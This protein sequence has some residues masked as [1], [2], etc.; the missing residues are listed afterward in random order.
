MR[1]WFFRAEKLRKALKKSLGGQSETESEHSRGD[2]DS[3]EVKVPQTLPLSQPPE[4]GILKKKYPHSLEDL[5]ESS[6]SERQPLHKSKESLHRSKENLHKS[7]EKKKRLTSS[8]GQLRSPLQLTHDTSWL[9]PLQEAN[10]L[11][12]PAY[13]EFRSM[14]P[15]PPS[16][17]VGTQGDMDEEEGIYEELCGSSCSSLDKKEYSDEDNEATGEQ[18]DSAKAFSE[19]SYEMPRDSSN[20]SLEGA[21]NRII[22]LKNINELLKQIDEQFNSVLQQT[23]QGDYSPTGSEELRGS[24]TEADRHYNRD[25][26]YKQSDIEEGYSPPHRSPLLSPNPMGSDKRSSMVSTSDKRNSQLTSCSSP[27]PLP[28][29]TGILSPIR[30]RSPPR[31]MSPI[32]E[33]MRL[34]S[35]SSPLS[36]P[37]QQSV[38]SQAQRRA[39]I[40]GSPKR[41]S[42]ARRSSP[43]R[44][45]VRRGVSPSREGRGSR[46]GSTSP[47]ECGG[48]VC[49]PAG[50]RTRHTSGSPGRHM[51]PTSSH[52]SLMEPPVTAVPYRGAKTGDTGSVPASPP[53]SRREDSALP[54]SPQCQRAHSIDSPP[55]G[56]PHPLHKPRADH[57]GSPKRT[58]SKVKGAEAA[59]RHCS[60]PE[61]N[62]GKSSPAATGKAGNP[63]L[64]ELFP[65]QRRSLSTDG[66]SISEGYHSD[67]AD[68]DSIIVRELPVERSDQLRATPHKRISY[69]KQADTDDLVNV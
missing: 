42:P 6:A 55:P 40:S 61:G 31:F 17:D 19:M 4:K 69:T 65:V 46:P 30:H 64:S 14:V 33:G 41:D 8:T 22:K 10:R 7:K 24:E 43:S 47:T 12:S 28:S 1:C 38:N 62:N 48:R 34:P 26:F 58:P 11:K 56:S 67:R 23:T 25:S 9:R 51:T 37:S 45:P 13:L 18:A 63:L 60:S 15:L 29:P 32:Q 27:E 3:T 16:R 52:T 50:H 66:Q 35:H 2:R 36:S 5:T 20:D 49:S 53:V 54:P 44:I 39:D 21:R 57:L 68:S 59:N